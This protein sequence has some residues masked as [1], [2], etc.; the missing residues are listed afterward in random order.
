M[1]LGGKLIANP[2]D[3]IAW[4]KSLVAKGYKAGVCP[5]TADASD[6]QVRLL[7]KTAKKHDLLIAEVGVWNS[8]LDRDPDI[9]RQS[10]DYCKAQLNLADRVGANCCVNISGSR[11]PVRN[12]PDKENFS[13]DTFALV[14][15][16]IRDIIDAVKPKRTFYALECM[17]FMIPDSIESYQ[18][19]IKSID[20]KAFGVHFDPVN[21]LITPRD[22]YQNGVMIRN[23]IQTFGDKIKSCH[24][25]DIQIQSGFPIRIQEV[26]AGLGILDYRTYIEEINKVNP[27][28]PL[29]IEHLQSEEEYQQAAEYIRKF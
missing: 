21:M 28:M 14:V 7:L 3:P 6:Q 10:I 20:R 8:P 24:A 5:L 22:Y 11:G 18:R 1:R 23:F 25:K 19:L 29:I 9:R 16:T 4:A 12:G 26:R 2:N 15:D 17:P 27:N 13:E